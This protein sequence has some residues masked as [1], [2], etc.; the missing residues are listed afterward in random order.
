MFH[1]RYAESRNGTQQLRSAPGEPRELAAIIR[2]ILTDGRDIPTMAR[3]VRALSQRLLELG[4]PLWR[5][6][7]YAATLHPQIHGFGWRWWR[8]LRATEEVRIQRGVELTYDYQTSPMRETIETGAHVRYRLDASSDKVSFLSELR[9][10]GG[11]DYVVVPLNRVRQRFPVAAWATDRSGGFDERDL[12]VLEAIR[13]AL[14]TLVEV[15][16]LRRTARSL[17]SIYH[18]HQVGE[19]IFDGQILRGNVDLLPAVIMATDLRGFTALSDRLPGESV[20][21]ALNDYFEHVATSVDVAGGL[22]LKFIGDGALAI[23][24]AEGGREKQAALAGLSAARE[25]VNRLDNY[26]GAQDGQTAIQLRAG[27]GLHIGNVLYGN[28]GAPDRLDFTVIGPAV[29]L[30]FRLE[31]LT[32]DLQRPILASAA[33]AQALPLPLRSLG[34]HPIRGLSEP[35]EVFGLTEHETAT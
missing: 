24:S 32:K 21:R 22:V 12:L 14:A 18:S 16:V 19:R 8:N 13:P 33:F 29:N 6:T 28:V 25:I 3:F 2:W 11:T 7:I 34:R 31:S 23:F 10:Q 4:V 1:R 35:E 26:V 5:V 20:V 15:N 9:A 30:A 27:V 17:F